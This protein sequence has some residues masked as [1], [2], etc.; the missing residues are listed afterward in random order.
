MNRLLH[1]TLIYY[2]VSAIFILLLSA[3]FIYYTLEKLY[4]EDVDEAI[5]LR[6]TE[7]VVNNQKDLFIKDIPQWNRFN[8]DTRIFSSIPANYS[9]NRILQQKFYDELVPEWEPYRVLYADIHI[10]GKPF[11]LMIRLNLVESEDL[12]K[13]IVWIYLGILVILLTVIFFITVLISNKLWK[14]FYTTLEIIENFNIEKGTKANFP[15]TKIIEFKQL[16]N[17]LST[18]IDQSMRSYSMQKMFTQNASHELQTPLAVFQSK[19]DLLLQDNTLSKEQITILHS[20]YQSVS[21]LSRINKNLLLLSKIENNQFADHRNFLLNDIISEVVP[22]FTEQAGAKNLLIELQ[23]GGE[24]HLNAN[25]VLTEIL[26]NNLLLNSIRHNI[27][28]GRIDILIEKKS[29]TIT[30]TG[31]RKGLDHTALFQRFGKK[32]TDNRSSGLGLAIVKEI[33]D[34]SGWKISYVHSGGSWHTFKV[35]FIPLDNP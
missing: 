8:R 17:R 10:E 7:F 30:N 15:A 32:S 14:P 35:D 3:P 33:C 12:I 31:Q 22:Y 5:F 34:Q 4:Q 24:L 18:L 21:K 29:L 1:K 16:N 28:N 23:I 20:L 2:S 25:K 9:R 19:L 13:T 6:K 11:I 27:E 26:I